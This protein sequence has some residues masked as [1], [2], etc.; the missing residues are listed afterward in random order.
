MEIFTYVDVSTF[1]TYLVIN[2]IYVTI[3]VYISGGGADWLHLMDPAAPSS[4]L[5]ID[6]GSRA[7]LQRAFSSSYINLNLAVCTLMGS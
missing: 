1:I 5:K 6:D 2:I 4:L 7:S 3:E